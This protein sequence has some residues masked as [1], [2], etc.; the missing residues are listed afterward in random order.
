MEDALVTAFY[1]IR[2]R[3]PSIIQN[4]LDDDGPSTD[5]MHR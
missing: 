1:Y 5:N 3:A 4:M 2:V